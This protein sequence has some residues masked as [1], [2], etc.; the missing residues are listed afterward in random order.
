VTTT[1]TTV[2]AAD[3]GP[4]ELTIDEQGE[5]RPHLLLHGGAGPQSM[6]RFA[7]LLAES[8][9]LRVISPTHPGFGGTRRPDHLNSVAG[10]ASLYVALLEALELEDVT[11]I[12]NSVG[13]WIAAELALRRSSRVSKLVLID[14]VGIEVTGHHVV[15]VAGLSVP[16]I[17]AL[18][19][20]DPTPFR[21]DPTTLSDQQK[22]VAASN[23]AAL[24]VYAGS[25]AMSDHTLLERLGAIDVPT[26]VLWGDSDGIVDPAYGQTYA[27]AIPGASFELL[28]ATGHMPQLESPE[29]VLRA[30]SSWI[31]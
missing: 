14:A 11:V 4:V 24:A 13:G 12:G 23:A 21:I 10:L 22:A 31:A 6:A 15:G 19:F 5:G 7:Q 26:L 28:A 16:E 25:P 3:I 27:S 30:I 2:D 9:D 1:S 18:S 20:Y 29:R 17:Q 8:N